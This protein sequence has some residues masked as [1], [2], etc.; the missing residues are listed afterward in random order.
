[1]LDFYGEMEDGVNAGDRSDRCAVRWE[2]DAP[3][4]G[5]RRRWGDARP[6]AMAG[7]TVLLAVGPDDTPALKDTEGKAVISSPVLCQVP[8]DIVAM[9]TTDPDKARAWRDAL[10]DTMGAAMEAGFVASFISRDGWYVL[11]RTEDEEAD[12]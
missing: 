5:R 3:A 7:G 11:T 12:E 9:R 1:M 6:T 10:G 8:A 4:G 2:L